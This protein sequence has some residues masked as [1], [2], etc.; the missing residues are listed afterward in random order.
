MRDKKNKSIVP[1]VGVFLCVKVYLLFLL[2]YGMVP[3]Y[4]H[5][6]SLPLPVIN[7]LYPWAEG[8]GFGLT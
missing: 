5:H 4:H 3:G 6:H 8:M 7:P 2:W 1:Y